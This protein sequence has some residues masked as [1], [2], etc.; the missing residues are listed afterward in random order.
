MKSNIR[1]GIEENPESI[2]S[3]LGTGGTY[4]EGQIILQGDHT[5]A[6]NE[7]LNFIAN[8]RPSKPHS[9]HFNLWSII[10]TF[11]L[12]AEIPTSTTRGLLKVQLLSQ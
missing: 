7:Q 12:V 4:K 11:H 10:V 6:V 5:E 1:K 9:I 3:E 2:S 8:Y